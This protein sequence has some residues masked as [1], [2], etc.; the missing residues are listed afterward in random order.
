MIGTA[1]LRAAPP[2]GTLRRDK[3]G[4]RVMAVLAVFRYAV[5]PGRMG[6]FLAK[7]EAA[8]EPRFDSPTMPRGVRL[9]RNTV[10]GPDT[11]PVILV[12]E[13]DDMAAYGARTVFEQANADWRALFEASAESPETLL[14]VELL[15]EL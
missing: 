4:T 12:L 5:K 7:L 14:A 10:P 9:F 1:G 13:Y 11:G 2:H 6:D 3:R 8:A 15:T